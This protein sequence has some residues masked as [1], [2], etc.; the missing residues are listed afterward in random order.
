MHIFMGME[1]NNLNKLTNKYPTILNYKTV[2]VVNTSKPSDVGN[3][4]NPITLQTPNQNLQVLNT[5][6]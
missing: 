1:Y 5:N 6:G 4:V 2:G 3:V